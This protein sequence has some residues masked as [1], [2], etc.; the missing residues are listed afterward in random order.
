MERRKA[1]PAP[2]STPFLNVPQSR[3]Y[4]AERLEYKPPARA[5]LPAW[6]VP[7][8]A[9]LLHCLAL[10]GWEGEWPIKDALPSTLS[11]SCSFLCGVGRSGRAVWPEPKQAQ[12]PLPY[13]T[14]KRD[15]T[16]WLGFRLG[17][18]RM[19]RALSPCIPSS[20]QRPA[21]GRLLS[22]GPVNKEVALWLS[23]TIVTFV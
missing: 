17:E 5:D 7:R 10:C 13:H 4:E 22:T 18:S 6:K 15:R 2:P 16:P 11:L 12:G 19:K 1:S 23:V 21:L 20:F 3:D 14:A 9:F 8:A